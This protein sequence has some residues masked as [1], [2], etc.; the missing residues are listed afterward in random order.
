MRRSPIVPATTTFDGPSD[1][2]NA[3]HVFG[4]AKMTTALLDRLTHQRD[5]VETG[6]DSWCF[7]CCD[8]DHAT[9]ARV[10]AATPPAPTLRALPLDHADRRAPLGAEGAHCLTWNVTGQVPANDRRG[11]AESDR[12]RRWRNVSPAPPC[13]AIVGMTPRWGLSARSKLSPLAPAA[14]HPFCPS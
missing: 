7:K 2:T 4:G 5:I 3:P 10:V 11:V 13:R 12:C 6:N 14:F 8:D 1:G 9:R